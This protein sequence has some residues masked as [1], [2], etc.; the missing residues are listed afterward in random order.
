MPNPL[1]TPQNHGEA[2]YYCAQDIVGP[3]Q[4]Q[5]SDTLGISYGPGVTAYNGGVTTTCGGLH[6]HVH[7][8]PNGTVWLPVNQCGG[9]QGGAVSTDNDTTWHEFIVTGSVSQSQ[10]ADPSVGLDFASTAYYCYVNNEPV[11]VG[12]PPEGHVHVKVST[13]GGATWIRD[14]DLGASHGIKNAAHTEAVGGSTNRAACGFI[15]TNVAGDYQ[16]GSFPGL[17]YAFI[18]TTYDGGL[19]W[20]TVNATPNDPVQSMTGIWQQGGG[21]QDRNLLDFNE[22]TLDDKGHVLYGYSDGC[23]SEPCIGGTAGNDYTGYMRVARQ[24]GG[25]PMLALFDSTEPVAPKPPCL[26]GT[27]DAA[28]SHL[29]WKI[30]D[31]GGSDIIGYQILRGLTAGTE[32][33]LVHSTGSNRDTYSDTT[34]LPAVPHYFYMVKAIN[35]NASPIGPQSNEIDLIVSPTPPPESACLLPGLTILTD[36]PN[37]ELNQV[38]GHDVQHLWIAEPFAFAPNQVVFTLKMQSLATVPPNTRWPVTFDVGSPAVNYTVRMTNVPADGATTTPIFQVGPS[39]GPFVAAAAGSNFNADGTITM[40]VPKSAIG[41]PAAGQRLIGFLTRIAIFGGVTT[42]TPDNMP[43]SLAPT[44]SYT[45]IGNEACAPTP[46]PPP[47]VN[48]TGSISY[49][50]NPVPNPVPGVT[51]TLTGGAS[52]ST[53]SDG[54]GNYGFSNVATGGSYTITPAKAARRRAPRVLTPWTWSPPNGISSTRNSSRG[55]G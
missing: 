8:A 1:I 43:D 16:S 23:T 48:I 3:A 37:D 19:T 14:F 27:R 35:T 6:G 13:D 26:S 4:C 18:A 39:A 42:I 40:V 47:F 50:S 34:A 38:P 10:G 12:N 51:L 24:S 46:T 29:T 44:G 30:P 41:N 45:V 25:K 9:H 54:S 22:I 28:A 5:R 15:G 33:V 21:N 53:S 36:P 55:A 49:C 11:P 32:S 52:G 17:W 31:N 2:V 7:V 20:T